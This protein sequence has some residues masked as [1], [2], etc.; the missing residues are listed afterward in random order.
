M[1]CNH[2]ENKY[3]THANYKELIIKIILR[4]TLS[5]VFSLL[6]D[7]IKNRNSNNFDIYDNALND[8]TNTIVYSV[9]V[10]FSTTKLKIFTFTIYLHKRHK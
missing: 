7:N 10:S 3:I 2:L 5:D 6:D 9:L 8:G 4:F 1:Y